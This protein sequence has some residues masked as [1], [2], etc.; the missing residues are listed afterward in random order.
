[1]SHDGLVGLDNALQTYQSSSIHFRDRLMMRSKSNLSSDLSGVCLG[2]YENFMMCS[3]PSGDSHNAHT[4]VM[5]SSPTETLQRN[6]D[7]AWS[8]TWRG[9]RPVEWVTGVVNGENRCFCLSRDYKPVDTSLNRR[10]RAKPTDFVYNVW[11]GF[12]SERADVGHNGSMKRI[13]CAFET[14]FYGEGFML[15]KFS[16]AQLDLTEISGIV[17]IEVYY[18]GLK[19]GY[20]RILEKRIVATTGSI[21][22]PMILTIDKDTVIESFRPQDRMIRT[23]SIK[24]GRAANNQNGVESKYNRDQDR[25]FSLLI[26]WTGQMAIRSLRAYIEAV[27]EETQGTCEPD[28]SIE[29]AITIEG[30]GLTSY[31]AAIERPLAISPRSHYFRAITPRY[32]ELPYE[33]LTLAM[34][35]PETLQ[36]DERFTPTYPVLPV[37]AAGT[38]TQW[39]DALPPLP[40]PTPP[41]PVDSDEPNPG[42]RDSRPPGWPANHPDFKYNPPPND[43]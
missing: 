15:K 17:D 40:P 13:E 41:P 27:P 9:I 37:R 35:L 2:G 43:P 3:V 21:G 33:S 6:G 39:I 16:F 29:Q 24:G 26:R 11:E 12:I 22:S 19:G 20:E 5:D 14:K 25:A 23:V 31:V 30:R 8:G 10:L 34:L 36:T 42:F 32:A 4:W 7:P 1:M 18:A 38:V 28:E